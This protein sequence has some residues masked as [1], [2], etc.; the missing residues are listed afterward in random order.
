MIQAAGRR[1]SGG[2][3]N[4]PRA[5]RR[6][7]ARLLRLRWFVSQLEI[8]GRVVGVYAYTEPYAALQAVKLFPHAFLPAVYASYI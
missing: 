8:F 7:G 6:F 4:D 1:A 2:C 5:S 3:Q